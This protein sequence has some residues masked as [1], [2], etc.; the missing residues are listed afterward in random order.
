LA[1]LGQIGTAGPGQYSSPKKFGDDAK[2]FTIA[3]KRPEKSNEGVGP[4]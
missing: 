1:L 2:T 4:G 3:E